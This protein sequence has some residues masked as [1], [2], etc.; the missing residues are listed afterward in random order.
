MNE[1][2]SKYEHEH[3]REHEREHKNTNKNM[4]TRTETRKRNKHTQKRKA[5]NLNEIAVFQ[6]LH[7]GSLCEEIGCGTCFGFECF[8]G[9]GDLALPCATVD[10]TVLA[11]AQQANLQNN[12][13]KK[14]NKSE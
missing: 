8:D 10:F 6:L 7:N 2:K 9:H 11:L 13:T 1:K 5:V 4:K 12:N 3:E 14:G